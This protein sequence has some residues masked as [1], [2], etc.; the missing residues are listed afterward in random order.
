MAR[1]KLAGT[2]GASEN[3]IIF[4]PAGGHSHNGRNS[5]LIDSTAYSVYDFSPTFVG[6]EVNPD[7]AI[8]QE[9]NRIALEDLI[10]RVVNNAVLRPAGIRLEP[11]SLNGSL[12]IANTITANQLAANT[13]TADEIAVGTI[14]ANQLSSNIVLV[15]NI[16]R[17]NNY[18]GTIAAN[19]VITGQGTV[20]W[21]ITHAGSA[22]FSNASIRGT[23]NAAS[24]STPGVDILANGAI[25]A[26]NFNVTPT[27]NI[28]ATNANIS[29]IITSGS[30][31]IGGWLIDSNSLYSGTKTTSGSYTTS[32]GQMTIGSDGHISAN[33]FRVNSD[34]SLFATGANINGAVTATTLTASTSG[35]IG[36]WKISSSGITSANDLVTMSSSGNF[37]IGTSSTDKATITSTGDFTVIG[38]GGGDYGVGTATFFGPWY[39]IKKGSDSAA[40]TVPFAQLTYKDFVFFTNGSGT[41]SIN[42]RGGND[43]GNTYIDVGATGI[44]DDNSISC[45]GWFRSSGSTGWYNQTYGGG[46]F[47]DDPY[48]VK[49]Y[50]GK[51]IRIPMAP[52][53][54]NIRIDRS[55]HL[56]VIGGQGTMFAQF[57]NTDTFDGLY[58]TGLQ[59]GSITIDNTG[60]STSFNT[61]SDKRIKKD[62]SSIS[63]PIEIINNINPVEYY[64]INSETR[65]HGFIAQEL[66]EYYPNMVTKGDDHES[67]ISQ[68]WS[69]DYSKI[70]PLLTAAVKELVARVEKLESM[71]V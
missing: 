33:K 67:V 23:I 69:I 17:S 31:A 55:G 10:K 5:S 62:I 39:Q 60:T 16:I 19:G 51:Q 13:I 54:A 44:T 22:V 35:T 34:G 43:N 61:G 6:T 30:G 2:S 9:N 14:T 32:T 68:I 45:S 59:I 64:M 4:S 24:V 29:G 8:R 47:M 63:N 1:I 27:G 46:I 65:T 26:T 15:N 71:M 7:R 28:S 20:G 58:P 49:V 18:D 52:N 57:I 70:T 21:A 3:T 40:T 41:Y 53:Q 48:S 38:N 42:I 25:V 37:S 50:N 11:G 66:Y 36:G 56:S 12:I